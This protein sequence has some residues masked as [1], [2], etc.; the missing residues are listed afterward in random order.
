MGKRN[1]AQNADKV[2]VDR[3]SAVGASHFGI[4]AVDVAKARSKWMLTTF[5]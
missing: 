4:V 1:P 3:V 5:L 2:F